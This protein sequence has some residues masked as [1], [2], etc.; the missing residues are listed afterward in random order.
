M[1]QAMN[2]GHVNS[3]VDMLT[4]LETMVLSGS[5]LPLYAVR[6]QIALVLDIIVHLSRLRD[7]SKGVL[8]ISGVAGFFDG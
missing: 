7:K 6:R 3:A 8:E 5:A 4:R 2:I 1:L